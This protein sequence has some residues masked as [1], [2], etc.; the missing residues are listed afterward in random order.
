MNKP[1]LNVYE[2]DKDYYLNRTK[3]IEIF[4]YYSKYRSEDD[5]CQDDCIDRYCEGKCEID[6]ST[7]K[8]KDMNLQKII[9]LIPKDV[10]ISDVKFEIDLDLDD[11]E[12][13]GH[14]V[15]FYYLKSL[16]PDK[17]GYEKAKK[18]FDA[19]NS[20]YLEEKAKYDV[21][22]KQEKINK[23]QEELEKLKK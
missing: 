23:L 19:A 16:K 5:D 15:T 18:E 1:F 13:Y 12:I 21:W 17:K 6:P 7:I 3:R 22:E 9:D 4:T 20:K 2:P 10:S 8:I 11:M 14:S